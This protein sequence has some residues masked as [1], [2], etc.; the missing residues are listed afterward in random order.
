M[1]ILAICFV[2]IQNIFQIEILDEKTK[3]PIPNATIKIEGTIYLSN[4]KGLLQL[5][6][7]RK[8][9]T[10]EVSHI[11]YKT[12]KYSVSDNKNKYTILL[13]E[14]LF[15]D[16]V[17]DV[18]VRR[19]EQINSTSTEVISDTI[20]ASKISLISTK[21]IVNEIE[22]NASITT[23]KTIDGKKKVNILNS[24]DGE[25]SFSIN[26]YSLT[27][28]VR[29][30]SHPD[31]LVTSSISSL[32]IN[33][34]NS[35]GYLA[36][37]ASKI[38]QADNIV[39]SSN[40]SNTGLWLKSTLPLVKNDDSSL[41]LSI[42]GSAFSRE[43]TVNNGSLDYVFFTHQKNVKFNSIYNR[44]LSS[45][46]KFEHFF[47]GSV[48]KQDFIDRADIN[49]TKLVNGF[50]LVYDDFKLVNKTLYTRWKYKN[51]TSD[52]HIL[53]T[54]EK[55]VE[56]NLYLSKKIV[57]PRTFFIF[58]VGVNSYMNDYDER[59]SYWNVEQSA[60]ANVYDMK[61][62]V[63]V[64]PSVTKDEKKSVME[65]K[66]NNKFY[67]DESYFTYGMKFSYFLTLSKVDHEFFIDYEKNKEPF[68]QNYQ[69]Y[70]NNLDSVF[71]SLG[72]SN[73]MIGIKSKLKLGFQLNM[74]YSDRKYDNFLYK[75]YSL[76]NDKLNVSRYGRVKVFNGGLNYNL[77][78]YF[79]LNSSYQFTSSDPFE[80]FINKPET[81]LKFNLVVNYFDGYRIQFDY[82]KKKDMFLLY[83]VDGVSF[84]TKIQDLDNLNINVTK[85]VFDKLDLSL[86]ILNALK[87]KD[88][89]INGLSYSEREINFGTTYSF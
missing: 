21:N 15:V 59:I 34:G 2:F 66:L 12:K 42:A 20:L 28:L 76:L 57:L 51:S 7:K 47:A 58:D 54:F 3:K 61:A 17:V 68:L 77:D 9:Q 71:S 60:V 67:N 45:D 30:R 81:Q 83:E 79:S 75:S 69:L 24:Q 19:Q 10:I 52:K 87:S 78:K 88:I 23:D 73:L 49:E 80:T 70:T 29:K 35:N 31:L 6:L 14:K 26:D 46:L 1:I 84:P 48:L 43:Y 25:V 65:L 64:T 36:N 11:N 37:V 72:F 5:D 55:N 40:I 86:S 53:D 27:E 74:Y 8:P 82:T 89:N 22:S 32:L 4:Q 18:S 39:L 50:S 33:F 63:K 38:E 44:K 41:Q 56:N 85:K 13:T 16:D 62:I